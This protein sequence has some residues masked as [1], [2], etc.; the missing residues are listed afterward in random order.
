MGMERGGVGE[1]LEGTHVS[2]SS[3]HFICMLERLLDSITTHSL[4][5]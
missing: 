5:D 3:Q 1:A 4:Y 2:L